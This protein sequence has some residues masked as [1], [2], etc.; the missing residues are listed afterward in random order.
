MA[1]AQGVKSWRA[2]EFSRRR[3]FNLPL[4]ELFS[5]SK[6]LICDFADKNATR[7]DKKEEAGAALETGPRPP[8]LSEMRVDVVFGVVR[9]ESRLRRNSA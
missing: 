9:P 3:F 4:R 1:F 2:N 7:P 8:F 5:P 6:A